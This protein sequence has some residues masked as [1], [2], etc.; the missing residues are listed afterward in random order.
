MIQKLQYEYRTEQ[1]RTYIIMIYHALN[2]DVIDR[3]RKDYRGI[4]R[5]T[6]KHEKIDLRKDRN[7]LSQRW[8]QNPSNYFYVNPS[9]LMRCGSQIDPKR[10]LKFQTSRINK[11]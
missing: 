6:T 2:V 3:A 4:V 1:G 10:Q 11:G 8:G 7:R 9:L 5:P